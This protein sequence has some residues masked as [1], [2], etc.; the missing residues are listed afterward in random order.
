MTPPILF[1]GMEGVFSRTPLLELINA[2]HNI[3]AMI[4]PRPKQSQPA[5]EPIRR[6]VPPR[7]AQSDLPL[8]SGGNKPNIVGIAWN[9]GIDVYEVSSL[10]SDATLDTLQRLQPNL[11]V[12]ACFPW[13]LPKRLVTQYPSLNLHPSLLPAYRGP[14]PLFWIFHDGLE[15]AGVTIH[16][17]DE[18]ADTGDI[19]AQEQVALPDGI[20]Y[21]DAEKIL[22][23]RA[24]HLLIRVL[25]EASNGRFERTPQARTFAPHAP[26]PS[27]RDY[28]IAPNWSA[29]RAFNF[30]RGVGTARLEIGGQTLSLQEAITF[31]EREKIEAEVLQ[32]AD[33][34]KIQL[35]DGTLTVR[36]HNHPIF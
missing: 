2:H 27:E 14:A 23:G 28:V 12:V 29:R 30:I 1:F 32:Q 21:D 34:F 7:P 35:T 17:M 10:R 4:V 13:L 36:S 3:C 5:H 9:A 15:L 25:G 24:A 19:V 18:H 20:P 31:D 33:Q 26:K 6:L 8:A 16:L 11:I 22:S